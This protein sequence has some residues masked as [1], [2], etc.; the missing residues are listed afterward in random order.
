MRLINV[1]TLDIGGDKEPQSKY[2]ILSH[3]WG[4]DEVTFDTYPAA[5]KAIEDH[6]LQRS[7]ANILSSIAKVAGACK[8]CRKLKLDYLWIDTCCI[9]KRSSREENEAINSMFNWYEEAEVCLT[10]MVDV[11][12]AKTFVQSVWF[13]RGWTLQ[14]LLAPRKIVFYDQAW[15]EIGTKSSLS[16]QITAATKIS[17]QHLENFR[18]ASIATKMSWQAARTTTRTEDLAYSMFGIFDV[19]MDIRYGERHKAFRRLQEVIVNRYPQDESILAWTSN[20]P[21]PGGVLA[22]SVHCFRSCAHLIVTGQSSDYRP[23]AEY[24][25]SGRGFEI[26]APSAK[27]SVA[28]QVLWGHATGTGS[29][30]ELTLNCWDASK[31]S[32][33]TVVLMVKKENG[34]IYQRTN[35]QQLEWANNT[36]RLKDVTA[37]NVLFGRS[38]MSFP[39]VMQL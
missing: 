38:T 24:R 9:D 36:R 39:I 8:L 7:S 1:N 2:A 30:I 3:R 14:E 34:G 5:R 12:N 15:D 22:P 20:E 23:R 6:L 13:T 21:G 10:Y 4:D 11:G 33:N 29:K 25:I 31:P 17:H 28:V 16:E 19:G 26:T 32:N 18:P 37:V 35:C 27:S